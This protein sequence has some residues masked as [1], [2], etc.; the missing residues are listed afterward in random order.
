MEQSGVVGLFLYASD[1]ALCN[2]AE[3]DALI[4]A[5]LC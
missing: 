1:A 5:L 3:M 2:L 4:L